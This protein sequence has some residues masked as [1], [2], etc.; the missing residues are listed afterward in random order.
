MELLTWV[1]I[2]LC[3]SQSA[4]FSGLNL[5]LLGVSRLRL[6][7]EAETGGADA[8]TVLSLRKDANFLLSTILWGNVSVNVLLTLLSDSVMTGGVAFLFSTVGITLGGEILPQ[9]YFSRHALWVGARLAP[10][11]RFYQLLLYPIAKPSGRLLDWTL[12]GEALSYW[13]E[14]DIRQMIKLHVRAEESDVD[15]LEG[16]GVLNFL[17][18]DDVVVGSEGELINPASVLALPLGT[19]RPI[20]PRFDHLASD[21]FLQQVHASGRKWVVITDLEGTPQLALDADGF[22]RDALL[23]EQG[24]DPYAFCHRPIVVNDGSVPIGPLLR[25]LRVEPETGD[26]DV[27]DLDVLLI[28]GDERRVITGADLLGRLLRGITSR[29]APV[30]RADSQEPRSR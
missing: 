3:L 13:S 17:A 26:D 15:A 20:F 10:V 27:V 21:P 6:Q 5:A 8:K 9:A 14:R 7:A 30:V 28:W 19:E 18:L 4:T 12:G 2:C 25:Q 16:L 23:E 11:V 24:T 1:G 29:G 22:L